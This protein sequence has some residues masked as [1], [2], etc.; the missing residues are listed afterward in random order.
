MHIAAGSLALLSGIVPM[1][2][3]KGNKLHKRAGKLY[4]RSM[5]VV[6]I[7][8][9]VLSVALPII[10]GTPL[11]LFLFVVG[12]F[13][14]YFVYS[15][16]RALKYHKPPKNKPP[17]L[18]DKAAAALLLASGLFLVG[19]NFYLTGFAIP[20]PIL[21][22]FGVFAIV[23]AVGD[24]RRFQQTFDAKQGKF[25]WFYLHLIRMV[26]SYIAAVTAFM[27]VNVDFFPPIMVWATPGIVGGLGIT[28]WVRYY[29]RKFEG[30]K[31]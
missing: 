30:G 4:S 28:V 27:V 22:G 5:L 15:G 26:S 13:S 8:A 14:Y 16:L 23:M 21:I 20:N 17:R 9:M 31:L 19:Y 11:K 25:N 29:R 24:L 6:L 10:N 3:P 1:L 2:T 12:I 18:A 7:T